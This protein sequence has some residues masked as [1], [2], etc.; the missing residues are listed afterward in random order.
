MFPNIKAEIA[1][2]NLTMCELANMLKV[3]RKTV[4]KWL[5]EGSIPAY[6]LIKMAEIFN[7]TIDYL[8]GRSDK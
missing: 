2:N 5:N 4:S 7:V 6:A 1:R 3:N 8:L